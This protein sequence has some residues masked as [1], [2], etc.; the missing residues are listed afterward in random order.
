MDPITTSAIIS[1]IIGGLLATG[2]CL[3]LQ[4]WV[5]QVCNGKRAAMLVDENRGTI[6]LANVVFFAGFP[7]SIYIYHSGLLDN[8]DWR[9]FALG[10]GGGSI[11]A[12][13]SLILVPL[14]AGRRPGEALVAYAI[15]QRTPTVV[16]YAILTAAVAAFAFAAFSLVGAA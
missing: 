3:L 2:L 7:A 11:L 14:A 6:R 1:G 8:S 10:A 5:P 15:S 4:R 13:A 9:G 16:L 12:L